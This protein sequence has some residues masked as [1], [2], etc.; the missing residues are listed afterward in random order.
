MKSPV[1]RVWKMTNCLLHVFVVQV[2]EFIVSYLSWNLPVGLSFLTG[3]LSSKSVT[4]SPIY[5]TANTIPL[6]LHIHV[7]T[8][9][10]AKLG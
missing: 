6:K 9:S 7:L 3:E 1:V 4:D 2:S 5:S 8:D 10:R